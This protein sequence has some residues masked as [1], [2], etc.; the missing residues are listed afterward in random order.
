MTDTEPSLPTR[1]I[2]VGPSEGWAD[3]AIRVSI[4]EP[5]ANGTTTDT[6]RLSE[7]EASNLLD[8]LDDYLYELRQA[9]NAAEAQTAQTPK[10]A[11]T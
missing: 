9:R 4:V 10:E 2:V 6:F 8:A 3:R 11:T 7:E 5:Y 1:E